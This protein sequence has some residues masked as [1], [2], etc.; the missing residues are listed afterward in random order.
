MTNEES[1]KNVEGWISFVHKYGSA[2]ADG[3]SILVGNKCDEKDERVI[4]EKEARAFAAE[5]KMPYL[6]VSAKENTNIDE[7]FDYLI[8]KVVSKLP[9]PTLPQPI[10]GAATQKDEN[11]K[12]KRCVIF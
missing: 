9:E 6:E 5:H 3:C 10:Q 12:K 11:G 7:T 8:K 4:F 2:R 1:F